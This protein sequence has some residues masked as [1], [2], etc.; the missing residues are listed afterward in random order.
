M[1]EYA[2]PDSCIVHGTS[3]KGQARSRRQAGAPKSQA[4]F[5]LD[6]LEDG[7]ALLAELKVTYNVKWFGV[8][9]SGHAHRGGS[10]GVG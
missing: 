2:I 4:P 3:V 6:S 8:F 5:F 7:Q 1:G 9:S 10:S